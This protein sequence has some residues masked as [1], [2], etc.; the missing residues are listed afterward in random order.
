MAVPIRRATNRMMLVGEG[1]SQGSAIGESPRELALNRKRRFGIKWLH[2][3][4]NETPT[5]WEGRQV[6]YCSG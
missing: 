3:L 6:T 5:L 2:V 4:V 1:A